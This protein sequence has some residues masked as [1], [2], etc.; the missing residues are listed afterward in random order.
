[1]AAKRGPE[2]CNLGVMWAGPQS[3]PPD[4]LVFAPTI[5]HPCHLARWARSTARPCL[6][7]SRLLRSQE[8]KQYHSQYGELSAQSPPLHR[9]EIASA[10]VGSAIV[11]R[12]D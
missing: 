6:G 10:T 7:S 3:L 11:D 2:G 4:T 12:S 9:P 5:L 8:W 1:M